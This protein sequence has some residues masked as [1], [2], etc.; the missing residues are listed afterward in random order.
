MPRCAATTLAGK[1]CS[2]NATDNHEYCHV[3]CKSKT[4]TPFKELDSPMNSDA[5]MILIDPVDAIIDS[6]IDMVKAKLKDLKEEL[7]MLK[8]IKKSQSSKILTKA[9][10]LFY[11]ENKGN[12]EMRTEITQ[13]LVVGG[14]AFPKKNT[15]EVKIPYL[16]IKEYTDKGFF[17]LSEESRK[18]YMDEAREIILESIHS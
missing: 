10:W 16:L 18:P 13:K 17:Q 5:P 3:H 8:T 2:K 7:R 11:H 9:R 15:M 6:E 14:L 1:R 12:K 4:I